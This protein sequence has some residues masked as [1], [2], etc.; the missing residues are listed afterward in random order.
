MFVQDNNALA[1]KAVPS[2]LGIT[3]HKQWVMN[4]LAIPKFLNEKMDILATVKKESDK[5]KYSV[6]MDEAMINSVKKLEQGTGTFSRFHGNG[7]MYV[8]NIKKYA[9]ALEQCRG[10]VPE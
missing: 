7:N 5:N 8:V 4:S 3:V 1:F 2:M 10:M 9:D 6:V